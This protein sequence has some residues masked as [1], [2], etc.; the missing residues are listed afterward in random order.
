[1]SDIGP[2]ERQ[3]LAERLRGIVPREADTGLLFGYYHV[4]RAVWEAMGGDVEL[5]D[6]PMLL[7]ELI[8][9]T[10]EAKGM[11]FM[12]APPVHQGGQQPATSTMGCSECGYPFGNERYRIHGRPAQIPRFCPNCGARVVRHG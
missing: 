12:G 6:V 7:A 4:G 3:R 11:D 9:P 5:C 8:D 2:D 1:M 10:C